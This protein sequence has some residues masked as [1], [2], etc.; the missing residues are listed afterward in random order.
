MFSIS[1]RVGDRLKPH[2]HT[3]CSQAQRCRMQPAFWKKYDT[4]SNCR[5]RILMGVTGRWTTMP[6]PRHILFAYARL[7]SSNYFIYYRFISIKNS[8]WIRNR[9]GLDS[10][11][12]SVTT[13]SSSHP[14]SIMKK[15]FGVVMP[16]WMYLSLRAFAAVVAIKGS[17]FA[18]DSLRQRQKLVRVF[19]F[20]TL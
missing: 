1:N 10:S 13:S 20:T 15:L 17:V 14:T 3:Q 5:A 19:K 2:D 4:S 9:I 7:F 12:T 6:C 16:D 8:T 18:V 11:A